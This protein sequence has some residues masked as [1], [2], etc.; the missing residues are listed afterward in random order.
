MSQGIFRWGIVGQGAEAEGFAVALDNV[1]DAKLQAIVW[2]EHRTDRL[3]ASFATAEEVYTDFEDLILDKNIDLVYV[4]TS[5]TQRLAQIKALLACKKGVVYTPVLEITDQEWEE[6]C[7]TSRTHQLILLEGIASCFLPP[8]Q[9]TS[10]VITKGTVGELC[11][12]QADASQPIAFDPQHVFF[13]TQDGGIFRHHGLY[14]LFFAT[15]FLG[16]PDQI[17]GQIRIGVT[18]TEEQYAFVFHYNKGVYALLTASAIMQGSCEAQIISTKSR[19]Q[20]HAPFYGQIKVSLFN[21]NRP[22]GLMQFNYPSNTYYGLIQ[23]A[24]SCYSNKQHE[25]T[26]WDHTRTRAFANLLRRCRQEATIYQEPV[27]ET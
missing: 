13:S 25:S 19:V 23:E 9:K 2:N 15:Y 7:T 24:Q 17:S 12:I 6:V 22:S 8:L 4:A 16:V 26:Y 10:E 18:G 11:S 21:K 20:F 27:D 5:S 14:P 3:P 1:I